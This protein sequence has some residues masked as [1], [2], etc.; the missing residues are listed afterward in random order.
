MNRELTKQVV[1][2]FLLAT[3]ELFAFTYQGRL[4]DA[5]SP[6]QGSYD[7][8]FTLYDAVEAGNAVTDVYSM[9][10]VSLVN[11]YFTANLAF[12]A[13]ETVYNGQAR[14]LQIAMR[15][16]GT[17][18]PLTILSPRTGLS[19]VPYAERAHSADRLEPLAFLTD[20]IVKAEIEGEDALY[21]HYFNVFEKR[22]EVM[23][24]STGK[25]PGPVRLGD[26]ELRGFADRGTFF[27]AWLL[28]CET[29]LYAVE[30]KNI[31]LSVL[32][33]NGIIQE[34]WQFDGCFPMR[35][36]YDYD[37]A[38]GAAVQTVV[39]KP[40]VATRLAESI[41][42]NDEEWY[43]GPQPLV[44]GPF[45]IRPDGLEAQT[46][47]SFN[48]IGLLGTLVVDPDPHTHTV[49]LEVSPLDAV[50]TRTA[51]EDPEMAGWFGTVLGGQAELKTVGFSFD[52]HGEPLIRGHLLQAWPCAIQSSFDPVSQHMKE[53]IKLVVPEMDME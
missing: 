53:S 14:W 29:S 48:S 50:F 22:V 45:I 18:N 44:T 24:T 10:G 6:A 33:R 21:F 11:G 1:F 13:A 42:R 46:F 51:V 17:G 47:D 12:P 26:I 4:Y 8:Y 2:C 43:P 5:G 38:L 41:G 19:A 39:L 35:V 36:Q 34:Q 23:T 20:H 37:A 15:Q 9:P 31:R 28:R 32:D 49:Y 16:S 3:A 52:R 27:Y 40:A 25:T 7:L 30:R